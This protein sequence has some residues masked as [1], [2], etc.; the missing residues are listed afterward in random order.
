MGKRGIRV[1][2]Q[3]TK[4]DG[5]ASE[6]WTAAPENWDQMGE[7]NRDA[8]VSRTAFARHRGA[9]NAKVTKRD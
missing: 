9:Q 6:F 2:I 1:C 8:W 3:F 7:G 4:K 5:K